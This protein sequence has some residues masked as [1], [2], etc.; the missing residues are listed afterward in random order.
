[1]PCGGVLSSEMHML[2]TLGLGALVAGIVLIWLAGGRAL[3]HVGEHTLRENGGTFTPRKTTGILML[4]EA[5]PAVFTYTR[6]MR[7]RR[8]TPW[9]A[10]A[11]GLGLLLVV[12][13]ISTALLG[14]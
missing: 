1:M 5:I 10:Y 8:E 2:V 14:A 6:L 3:E 7:A 9:A 12:G 13:G 11:Y 4:I